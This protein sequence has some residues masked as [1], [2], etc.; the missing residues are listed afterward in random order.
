MTGF[1]RLCLV[2]VFVVFVLIIIGGTVRATGSGL[3]C[4]DWPHCHGS[5]IPRTDKHTLIEYSHR[6]TASIA[7]LLIFSIAAWAWRS[8]RHVPAILWP[9]TLAFVLM[10]A[11][12]GLGGA[13]VL[14]ELP[15]EIVA[16]HLAMALTLLSLLILLSTTVIS[17]E[18]P[19]PKLS[20]SRGFARTALAALGVTLVLMLVGS[21]VSGAGYGLACNGWP[22]CN[23]QVVPTAHSTSV[24]V[25]YLHR[26]LALTLGLV[27]VAL[28][29]LSRRERL[30]APIVAGWVSLAFAV[31]I[32]QA[33]VG[34]S[35]IWTRLADVASAGHLA[36]GSLFWIVLVS[37]VIRAHG[38]HE[39]L[40][41]TTRE[42]A[43]RDRLAGAVR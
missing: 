1:R 40:P 16:V 14:N 17:M 9:A 27:L 8:Y 26:V 29:W 20:V 32:A 6:L 5:F 21:Y 18:R 4:P 3:G 11:Q 38:L 42:Q 15:P 13:V 35:N 30:Q 22:L 31:Y 12:A 28:L 2:T 19:L 36:V 43:G 7:G 41:R 24:E 10:L 39:L 37:L 25:H 34:A 23:G 33:L